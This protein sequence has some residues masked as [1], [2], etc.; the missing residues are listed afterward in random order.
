MTFL[1]TNGYGESVYI[2]DVPSGATKVVFSNG[3]GTQT[4][5]TTLGSEGYYTD[6]SK[7]NGKYVTKPWA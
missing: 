6:G 3:N 7:N 5:D 2:C 1:E 4:V